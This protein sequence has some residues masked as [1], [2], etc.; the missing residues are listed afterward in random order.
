MMVILF[1][2]ALPQGTA[3]ASDI[4]IAYHDPS[5]Q[6]LSSRLASELASQGHRVSFE[7]LSFEPG[8]EAHAD[9]QA[10]P[11]V[12]FGRARIHL[13]RVPGSNDAAC[14]AI[15]YSTPGGVRQA[16]VTS[17]L[18]DVAR[19]SIRVA[20]ALNG[21]STRVP[22]SEVRTEVGVPDTRCEGSKPRPPI[23]LGASATGLLD[24]RHLSPLLGVGALA[25]LPLTTDWDLQFDVA[26]MIRSLALEERST[27][28]LARLA[29]TR[30]GVAFRVLPH[31]TELDV[32]AGIGA[33]VT[34]VTAN[35]EPPD[36]A[37][38][39]VAASVLFSAGG[40]FAYPSDAPVHGYVAL[41]AMTLAPAIRFELPQGATAPFGT[42]LGESAIGV[43]ASW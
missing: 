33:S 36:V 34:W 38:A 22:P 28:L 21:L 15:L 32:V 43:R 13:G 37:R 27:E 18:N 39:D 7:R 35:V 30:L 24:V 40:L 3:L 11:H 12:P 20:E 2:F 23:S 1:W 26:W 16:Q 5:L 14:A 4:T 42:L 9:R 31:P 17:S 41:R 6:P 10:P 29:W 19:F 8:C 25:E